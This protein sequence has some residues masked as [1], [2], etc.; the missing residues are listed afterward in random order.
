M[1]KTFGRRLACLLL[2]L[3][4]LGGAPGSFRPAAAGEASASAPASV[5]EWLAQESG[6]GAGATDTD[7]A[8]YVETNKDKFEE[9][10]LPASVVSPAGLDLLFSSTGVGEVCAVEFTGQ[11]DAQGFAELCAELEGKDYRNPGSENY[12]GKSVKFGWGVWNLRSP[13]GVHGVNFNWQRT[14]QQPSNRTTDPFRFIDAIPQTIY[15]PV[16]VQGLNFPTKGPNGR[17]PGAPTQITYGN[18]KITVENLL[19]ESMLRMRYSGSVKTLS[20]ADGN[21]DTASN[22]TSWVWSTPI[23]VQYSVS[24]EPITPGAAQ[25]GRP[26]LSGVQNTTPAAAYDDTLNTAANI[27]RG[28]N[29]ADAYSYGSDPRT[30]GEAG[31]PAGFRTT[32][33]G[34]K[35][36]SYTVAPNSA[37]GYRVG[38]YY[39]QTFDPV[40]G[41]LAAEEKLSADAIGAFAEKGLQGKTKIYVAYETAPRLE[42]VDAHGNTLEGAVFTV[43]R[44]QACT[45][46]VGSSTYEG[47]Q[48]VLPYLSLPVSVRGTG[49]PTMNP[50]LE[51]RPEEKEKEML[52][53][54][55][56][57][58]ETTAPEGAVP[59]PTVYTLDVQ[60]KEDEPSK[61]QVSIY[62][63]DSLNEGLPNVGELVVIPDT[64]AGENPK[65]V[66]QVVN[67]KAGYTMVKE[68]TSR[69]GETDISKGKGSAAGDTATNE[70]VPVYAPDDAANVLAGQGAQGFEA[71]AEPQIEYTVTLT[72]T[73]DLPLKIKLKD[74][75]EEIEQGGFAFI[76]AVLPD[77]TKTMDMENIRVELPPDDPATPGLNEGVAKVSFFFQLKKGTPAR[78]ETSN[79]QP[80]YAVDG[81]LNTVTAQ[82]VYIAEDHGGQQIEI[83]YAENAAGD[84]VPA[85]SAGAITEKTSSAKTPVVAPVPPQPTPTPAPPA[86]TPA[87]P[88][89]ATQESTPAPQ[90]GGETPKQEP[91][92]KEEPASAAPQAAVVLPQTSDDTNLGGALLLLLGGLAI[93]AGALFLNAK[94]YPERMPWRKKK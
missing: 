17:A 28:T 55:Y 10:S 37:P 20:G 14:Q 63:E 81:Y 8:H 27:D 2:A 21:A 64:G 3:C 68:R 73:G 18:D 77:G 65:P 6:L 87:P 85:D 35:G 72:N 51:L 84:I 71:G 66:C 75:Y 36:S 47:G 44:D 4:F 67:R 24:I 42:K 9:V 48:V 49:G 31:V 83:P 56:Y 46:L 60:A 12:G 23:Q 82:A 59:N 39:V 38:Y 53:L 15:L 40:T 74:A 11:T 34:S 16:P 1:K 25:K 26:E 61:A 22:A 76:R 29:G 43:Y 92:K 50:E 5:R 19:F 30:A 70:G 7:L 58:K 62:V 94:L 79:G 52:V 78:P 91:E 86:A 45:D 32:G 69:Y 41:E 33:F 57:L 89:A 90:A 80:G 13:I 54:R 93:C 88:P